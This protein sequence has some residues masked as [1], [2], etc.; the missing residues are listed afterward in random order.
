MSK[1][2]LEGEL[3]SCVGFL[4]LCM[5]FQGCVGFTGLLLANQISRNPVC[6]GL[7]YDY[8]VYRMTKIDWHINECDASVQYFVIL[9]ADKY[10]TISRNL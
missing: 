1:N 3:E 2:I 6:I 10:C 4:R 5:E 7:S 9:H 8:I